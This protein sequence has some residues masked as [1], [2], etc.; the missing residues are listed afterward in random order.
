MKQNQTASPFSHEL[1]TRIFSAAHEICFFKKGNFVNSQ[2]VFVR[3][4]KYKISKVVLWG[5][6]FVDSLP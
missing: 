5:A 1:Q 2:V 6:G 4:S 3:I